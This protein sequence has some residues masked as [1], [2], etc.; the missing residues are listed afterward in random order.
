MYSFKSKN[1][2]E[3]DGRYVIGEGRAALLKLIVEYESLTRA[4]QEMGMSY[5][6]AWGVLREMSQAF[7]KEIVHSERGGAEGGKTVL[8]PEGKELLEE[9]EKKHGTVQTL[10]SIGLKSPM[11][12]VDG[13]ILID[14]KLVLIRRKHYPFEGRLA[15][16]GGMVEYGEKVEGAVCREMKEETGLDV[17]ISEMLGVYSEPGRDPRGHTVSVA[18]VLERVGGKLRSGDDAK[19]IELVAIDKIPDLAFDHNEIVEDYI[20]WRKKQE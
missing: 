4:A 16:P 17:K 20:T 9:F 15:L 18:Y 19:A 8:T 3:K 2:I 1:W 7:G 11:L 13:L 6:H 12:A 14:D 5:R 10:I